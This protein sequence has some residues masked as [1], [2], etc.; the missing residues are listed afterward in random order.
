MAC[1][2]ESAGMAAGSAPGIGRRR[3][4]GC[5][6]RHGGEDPDT[7]N[8]SMNPDEARSWAGNIRIPAGA[9]CIFHLQRFVIK[10]DKPG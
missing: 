10:L 1:N 3:T 9:M 7:R 2:H 4:V 6:H 8:T 5:R